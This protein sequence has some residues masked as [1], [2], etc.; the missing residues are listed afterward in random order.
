[1]RCSFCHKGPENVGKLI[2]SPGD[3]PPAFICDECVAV[4]ADIFEDDGRQAHQMEAGKENEALAHPARVFVLQHVHAISDDEQDVKLIGLYSTRAR[5]E[6]A[7]IRLKSMQG[8]RDAPEGFSI[9]EYPA[10]E[11]NWTSGY[12]TVYGDPE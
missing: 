2:R 7:V 3:E 11:D 12:V 6:K 10:D 5:A 1:M 8:F 9:D 4:I